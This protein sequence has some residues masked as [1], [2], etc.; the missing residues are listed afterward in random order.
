MLDLIATG[1]VAVGAVLMVI[2]LVTSGRLIGDLPSGTVRRQ[3]RVLAGL[4]FIFVAAY[5]AY[6]V[7]ESSGRDSFTELL[8]PA[9]Y[10]LGAYFV[11]LVTIVS[12]QTARDVR[13][14]AVLEEQSITDPLMG[15][16][17]RRHLDRRLEEEMGKALRYGL[18]L[19]ALL[20]D[21]DHF[22]A[23]NDEHGHAV[24]DQVLRALGNLMLDAVRKADIVTRYGGEEIL[25]LAPHTSLAEG[26]LLA[27][28]LRAGVASKP[29]VAGSE[30]K[31]GRPLHATVSIG[32]A[33]LGPEVKDAATL[34]KAADDAL[35]RAK[36]EGRNRVV[37]A[38]ESVAA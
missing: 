28:R 31:D 4:I 15:V 25:V 13:R 1:L 12:L 11:V 5:V 8:F 9:A 36:R 22:K 32:V 18:P 2:A 33:A 37:T 19:A 35:Y 38:T 7:A 34:L 30:T 20:L 10:L 29:L 16:Y 27:E 24:G 21:L 3:W 14:V 6:L 26:R 23:I 17:N